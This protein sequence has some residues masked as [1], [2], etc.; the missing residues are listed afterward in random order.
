[1]RRSSLL[2]VLLP[3]LLVW[4]ALADLQPAQSAE[5]AAQPFDNRTLDGFETADGKR[6]NECWTI[7]DGVLH[8]KNGN[9]KRGGNLFTKAEFGDFQ[10]EFEWKISDK[11][12]NG[13]KYRVR[14]YNNKLLGLEYQ[15]YDD[16]GAKN[17]PQL[18]YSAGAIYDLYE[19]DL[20]KQLK[21]A[22][23][24]NTAKIV[25]RGNTIEHWLNGA[26]IVSAT[27]GDEEW[28]RRIK[29]SKFNE[30]PEFAENA[31]GKIMLTDHGS[32][33]W[34]RNFKFQTFE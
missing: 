30:Y 33:V 15:V 6:P 26:K 18:K 28:K 21:P 31:K 19:P 14:S 27:V 23:E 17:R 34:Y 20:G 4:F 22:G 1:M 12:N 24:F 5:P 7:E 11:G 32:E 29:A 16:L 8:L 10:L 25:V 13:L 2:A 9:G 3:L